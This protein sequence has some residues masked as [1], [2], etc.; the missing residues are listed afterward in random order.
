MTF[1]HCKSLTFDIVIALLLLIVYQ[2]Q[3][4]EDAFRKKIQ[5]EGNGWL[6]RHFGE[7]I[8]E[9]ARAHEQITANLQKLQA[10]K[11]KLEQTMLELS[12]KNAQQL[13]RKKIDNLTSHETKL[14]D[15]TEKAEAITYTY[16]LMHSVHQLIPQQADDEDMKRLLSEINHE[17]RQTEEIEKEINHSEI[18]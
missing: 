6:T 17:L 7:K 13:I 5:E 10:Q 14:T 11:Q 15:L 1:S 9:V 18:E 12:D 3:S 4:P 8:P 16:I 2:A